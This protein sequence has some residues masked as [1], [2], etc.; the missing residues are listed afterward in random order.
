MIICEQEV[1]WRWCVT[2]MMSAVTTQHAAA[3]K[4]AIITGR[5]VMKS[6]VRILQVRILVGTG[7][8]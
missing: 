4:Y 1:T 6:M 5:G 7:Q 2:E 8:E 3:R